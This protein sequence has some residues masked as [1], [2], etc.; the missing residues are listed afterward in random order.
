[1]NTYHPG[2]VRDPIAADLVP[3][4]QVAARLGVST[5]T[6]AK[7]SK[8]GTTAAGRTIAPLPCI[9]IVRRN[10]TDPTVVMYYW[11][12]VE[13]WAR[14]L[15][16]TRRGTIPNGGWTIERIAEMIGGVS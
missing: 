12:T 6:I 4:G 16:Q 13:T 5:Q 7:W 11:P 8:H 9:P 3:R 10:G 14:H 1:M 2:Y 15:A